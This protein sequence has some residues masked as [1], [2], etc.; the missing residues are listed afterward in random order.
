MSTGPFIKERSRSVREATDVVFLI[1]QIAQRR[2]VGQVRALQQ[3]RRRALSIVSD[4]PWRLGI[5]IL[6]V[7]VPSIVLAFMGPSIPVTTPGIVLLL[8][9]ACSTYLA[10]WVGGATS[11]LLSAFMLDLLFIGSRSD[12]GAPR[13]REEAIGFSITLV[14]GVALIWLIQRMKLESLVDR[15]AAVAARAAANALASVEAAAASHASGNVTTR[16]ALNHSLLR[17]MV[18]INRAHIGVLF[19][20]N[21][22]SGELEPVATYGLDGILDPVT[23][24]ADVGSAFIAQIALE[25]RARTVSD[26]STNRRM[27][28]SLLERAN[29]HA[30][31]GVP[32]I[33]ASENL[34]GVAIVGLFVPHRFTPTEIAR[35]DALAARAAAVLQA[36]VGIDQ[37]ETAL[38]SATE[39]KHWLELVIAA[40]PEA[41]VLAMPPDGRVV[42]ENQAA[43]ALLG[44]LTGP[45][46]GGDISTRIALPDGDPVDDETNP[47]KQA[48]RTGEVVTG[49][50]MLASSASGIQVPML[51]SAAPVREGDG[52]VVAVVAVFRDIA[53]L[54]E[55]SRLKDEFVSVVSHELRSPLT[56]IRGFVQLVA[57]DLA[58]EGGHD[59]QVGRLN[60]IAGHV[61]R[62]TRLVDDLLDVS[63]LKSGS[64]E[65]RTAPTD[66]ADLCADVVRDRSSTTTSHEFSFEPSDQTI[67]GEWDADRLYQVIDNLVGNAIK[68]TPA[69][70]SITVS[71]GFDPAT[72]SALVTV[73]DEGPGIAAADRAR[74]FSA[75]YRTPEA[76]ASR[77]AGL[78]LGL[79]ICHELVVA[80]GGS[81]EIGDA[82]GGG[83]AFKISLPLISAAI[84][85]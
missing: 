53:G 5:G 10:D 61:D 46:F 64:L 74:V 78:G 40:M 9:V 22:E 23:S 21:P 67:V 7:L 6:A 18:S 20:N 13:T 71:S 37:R 65:I 70:G 3:T 31:M 47:I 72:G 82:D 51:V 43:V 48:F 34:L 4:Q 38:H 19:L 8:A 56:P 27:S 45:D 29:V 14:C 32:L 36:A 55:A 15:R 28:R 66:L 42:A 75:F 76:A 81:I 49:V 1:A 73:S 57:R 17:A 63:R 79:Y 84:A 12:L 41:V 62:M 33:D 39:A 25:R 80:H 16:I 54:K 30:I 83:A 35:V 59:P 2:F 68:Y 60:S 58:R 11:L 50:E 26:L 85:A 44:H 52:P 24:P 77:I 69:G